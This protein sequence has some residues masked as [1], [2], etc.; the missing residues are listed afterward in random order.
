MTTRPRRDVVARLVSNKRSSYKEK[1]SD[2]SSENS[3]EEV[4]QLPEVE[5]RSYEQVQDEAGR[6]SHGP[7]TDYPCHIC[8]YNKWNKTR[9]LEQPGVEK[10]KSKLAA[11][12][13]DHDVISIKATSGPSAGG[14]NAET[15]ESVKSKDKKKEYSKERGRDGADVLFDGIKIEQKAKKTDDGGFEK[16]TKVGGKSYTYNSLPGITITNLGPPQASSASKGAEKPITPRGY[17]WPQEQEQMVE[18]VKKTNWAEVFRLSGVAIAKPASATTG[19]EEVTLEEAD[20]VGHTLKEWECSF[21]T[22]LNNEEDFKICRMCRGERNNTCQ[23]EKTTLGDI[24]GKQCPAC[25]LIN[26]PDC[27]TCAACDGVLF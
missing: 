23:E 18:I 25:T 4:V 11:A 14:N 26:K 24:M 10:D 19:K 17:L 1:S 22:F 5:D 2:S 6:C 3:E 13:G 8:C 9:R 16:P 15:R 12:G 20:Q 7:P 21:C 27:K